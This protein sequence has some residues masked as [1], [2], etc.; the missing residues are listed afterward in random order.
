MGTGSCPGVKSG[1][2]VT[3]TPHP[4]LVPWS[5]KIRAIPLLPL[6]A[7]QPVQSLS[8]CTRVHFTFSFMLYSRYFQTGHL[9]VQICLRSISNASVRSESEPRGISPSVG[10]KQVD[11]HRTDSRKISLLVFLINPVQMNPPPPKKKKQIPGF[12][13]TDIESFVF[14]GCW[15]LAGTWLLTLRGRLE[16]WRRD[17]YVVLKSLYPTTNVRRVSSQKSKDFILHEEVATSN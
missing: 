10:K 3:L 15:Q 12:R 1:R 14:L 2:G 17:R 9:K 16:P 6:W 7:V 13:Y 11:P 5:W 8:A 4:L